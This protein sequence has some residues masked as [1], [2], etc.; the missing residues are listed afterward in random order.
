MP[1]SNGLNRQKKL[2]LPIIKNKVACIRF[3]YI[4]YVN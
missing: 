3:V 4:T 2:I 1:E